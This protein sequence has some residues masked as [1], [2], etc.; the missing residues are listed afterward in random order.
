M[1]AGGDCVGQARHPPDLLP[2]I[3]AYLAR[4][5][6]SEL[7]ALVQFLVGGKFL[8]GAPTFGTRAP[9]FRSLFATKGSG[10]VRPRGLLWMYWF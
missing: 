5:L 4:R 7:D 8:P 3:L 10:E 9:D 2:D 1:S 6:Y